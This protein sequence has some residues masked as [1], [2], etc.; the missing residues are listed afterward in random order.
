VIGPESKDPRGARVDWSRVGR[1]VQ[2]VEQT[3]GARFHGSGRVRG[4]DNRGWLRNR[5][6]ELLDCF[7]TANAAQLWVEAATFKARSKDRPM[8]YFAGLVKRAAS[9][10]TLQDPSRLLSRVEMAALQA[11]RSKRDTAGEAAR[12]DRP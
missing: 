4:T 8:A 6:R 5:L 12:R 2:Y 3:L 11:E 7:P 10:R 9:D 1:A